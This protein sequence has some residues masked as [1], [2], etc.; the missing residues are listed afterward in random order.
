MEKGWLWVSEEFS[1]EN[2]Y[3]IEMDIIY[4]ANREWKRTL[5]MN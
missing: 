3:E 5:V 2:G 4:I 1:E